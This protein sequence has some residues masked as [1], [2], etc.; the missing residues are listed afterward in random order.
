MRTALLRAATVALGTGALVAAL[1]VPAGA[2]APVDRTRFQID[3]PGAWPC[4]WEEPDESLPPEDWPEP[5]Y[6]LHHEPDLRVSGLLQERGRSG[7][8]GIHDRITG[9][10]TWTLEGGDPAS[11]TD[12]HVLV[13]KVSVN[14]RDA[15]VEVESTGPDGT[16]LITFS[17]AGNDTFWLD[18]VRYRDPGHVVIQFRVRH[19]GTLDDPFD[20]H[21]FEFVDLVKESTGLNE[22][23]GIDPCAS[24]GELAGF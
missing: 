11:S 4:W 6:V 15:L 10:E 21:D 8:V 24:L 5:D 7:A 14:L 9:V 2:A 18:G 16:L 23:M 3:E 22:A 1:V 20:D 12:D 19:N 17:P 13:H